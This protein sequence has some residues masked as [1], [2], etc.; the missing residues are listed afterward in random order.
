V[1]GG[2]VSARAQAIAL[3]GFSGLVGDGA[4]QL[5]TTGGNLNGLNGGQLFL[6]GGLG[7]GLGAVTPLELRLNGFTGGRNSS[8]SIYQGLRTRLNGGNIVQM[9][10]R[11]PVAAGAGN[12]VVG[13]G[14][15]AAGAFIDGARQRVGR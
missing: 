3:G 13:S 1:L 7:G 11:Y 5:V 2:A 14:Q 15:Q 9:Q 8:L 12:A 6:A 4:G 10:L